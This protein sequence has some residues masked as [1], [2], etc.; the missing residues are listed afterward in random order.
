MD[1]VDFVAGCIGG[2]KCIRLYFIK[3][4]CKKNTKFVIENT[5]KYD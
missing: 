4:L 2:K 1:I 3:E 5:N